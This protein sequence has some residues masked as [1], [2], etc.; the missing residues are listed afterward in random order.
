MGV[1]IDLLFV[2]GCPNRDLARRNIDA[3][4]ARAALV[5][6]VVH[7]RQVDTEEVARTLGMGGSPTILV[8]GR[9]PFA[10]PGTVASLSCRLYRSRDAVSGAPSAE[11]LTAVLVDA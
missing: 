4:L 1:R 11:D 3:A 9:D 6:V 7:E 10:E 2:E 5:D 8:D